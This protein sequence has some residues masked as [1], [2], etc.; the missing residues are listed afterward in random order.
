LYYIFPLLSDEKDKFYKGGSGSLLMKVRVVHKDASGVRKWWTDHS[1]DALLV[2]KGW[3][4]D[5]KEVDFDR[6]TDF[7][8]IDLVVAYGGTQVLSKTAGDVVKFSPD[9]PLY[10]VPKGRNNTYWKGLG[11]SLDERLYGLDSEKV[12]RR[13]PLMRVCGD[14]GIEEVILNN[15]GIGFD[16]YVGRHC[17]PVTK[18]LIRTLFGYL[19]AMVRPFDTYVEMDGKKWEG[20]CTNLSVGRTR[21]VG[22]LLLKGD[23]DPMAEGNYIS[24]N[25]PLIEAIILGVGNGS[26]PFI[27]DVQHELMTNYDGPFT[28]IRVETDPAVWVRLDGDTYPQIKTPVTITTYPKRLLLALP[29]GKK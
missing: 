21:A 26:Y 2:E 7:S 19:V 14:G 22:H 6:H 27:V 5:F 23:V 1:K 9:V 20:R 12:Y 10:A 25:R 28:R 16:A 24:R 29:K 17:S 8:G 3:S 15:I 18:H 11:F 4:V 13:V